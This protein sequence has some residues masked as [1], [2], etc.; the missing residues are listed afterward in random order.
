LTAILGELAAPKPRRSTAKNDEI[1]N[2]RTDCRVRKF[3]A[4]IR[5]SHAGIDSRDRPL[6]HERKNLL[7]VLRWPSVRVVARRIEKNPQ[8]CLDAFVAEI[9]GKYWGLAATAEV[10]D[11]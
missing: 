10:V 1:M 7:N 8:P 9:A 6:G 5:R 2:A 3:P 4:P 11:S